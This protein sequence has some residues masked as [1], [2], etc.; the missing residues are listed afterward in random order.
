[1]LKRDVQDLQ[2]QINNALGSLWDKVNELERKVD[3]LSKPN[4]RGRPR[5]S[6]STPSKKTSS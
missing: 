6:A 2:S 3:E 4:T 5:K 1:M